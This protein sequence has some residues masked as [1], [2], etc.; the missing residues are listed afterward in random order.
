MVPTI[1]ISTYSL[2]WIDPTTLNNTDL[3]EV[4][5]LWKWCVIS[6]TK[7][8]FKKYSFYLILSVGSFVQWKPVV[9]MLWGKHRVVRGCGLQRTASPN[10]SA[11]WTSHSRNTNEA[12]GICSS[13]A[14]ILNTASRGTLKHHPAR[15]LL[16]SWPIENVCNNKWWWLFQAIKF[17][18]DLLCSNR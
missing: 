14:T 2:L 8:Y 4:Y 3:F 12:S 17:R 18:G 15:L 1:P 11:T 10:L 5:K 7:L 9:T 6:N 13:T 16:N